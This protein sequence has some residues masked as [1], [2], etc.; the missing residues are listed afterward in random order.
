[1]V[2]VQAGV[3][4]RQEDRVEVEDGDR[5]L[6]ELLVL[7][8]VDES[9]VLDDLAKCP[10]HG[11]VDVRYLAIVRECSCVRTI[12]TAGTFARA[13]WRRVDRCKPRFTPAPDLASS[14]PHPL[15]KPPTCQ[16]PPFVPSEVRACLVPAPR[17]DEATLSLR[18]LRV[19]FVV[20]SISHD[21]LVG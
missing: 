10:L 7:V 2:A 16:A 3:A 4:V 20:A 18:R 1:M 15:Q 8:K 19:C 5:L 14:H 12:S 6:V 13:Q 11:L 17:L 9:K 21:H